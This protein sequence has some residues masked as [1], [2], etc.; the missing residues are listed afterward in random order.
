MVRQEGDM[1]S[2]LVVHD[3]SLTLLLAIIYTVRDYSI[4][5]GKH[6]S[7]LL[8]PAGFE[9]S[10]SILTFLYRRSFII[11]LAAIH[12]RAIRYT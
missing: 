6:L 4:K 12:T 3:E 11:L 1:R 7:N 10:G 8:P 5:Y 2:G 9:I